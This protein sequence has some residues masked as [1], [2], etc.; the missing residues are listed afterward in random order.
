M[1]SRSA[2]EISRQRGIPFRSKNQ[3]T[4]ERT[5]PDIEAAIERGIGEVRTDSLDFSFGE[6]ISL[7]QNNELIIRP[8]FQR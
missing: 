6:L 8:D 1:F 4:K 2:D 7:F 3:A 5:M